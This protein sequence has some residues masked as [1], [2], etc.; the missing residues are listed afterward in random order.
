MRHTSDLDG[1]QRGRSNDRRQVGDIRQTANRKMRQGRAAVKPGQYTRRDTVEMQGLERRKGLRV[2]RVSAECQP[3]VPQRRRTAQQGHADLRY[4]AERPQVR[5]W[6]DVSALRR[7]ACGNRKVLERLKAFQPLHRVERA[8]GK[9][10]PSGAFE[11]LQTPQIDGTMDAH[12]DFGL[13]MP[14]EECAEHLQVGSGRIASNLRAAARFKRLQLLLAQGRPQIAH[15]ERTAACRCAG[16]CAQQP[17]YLRRSGIPRRAF[18]REGPG[19]AVKGQRCGHDLPARLLQCATAEISA[20]QRRLRAQC[21]QCFGFERAF[22][23][24]GE[25]VS[26]Q[27]RPIR[28]GDNDRCLHAAA[29]G[30]AKPVAALIT[31]FHVRRDGRVRVGSGKRSGQRFDAQNGIV[32]E[33]LIFLG[34]L[35]PEAIGD[36]LA[37][38]THYEPTPLADVDAILGSIDGPI[39]RFTF[40]D[41]GAGMG[42]MLMLAS[43]CPFRQ[44]VGIEVSSA[45]CAVARENVDRWLQ[46]RTDL[47]CRDIRLRTADAA[48]VRLPAGALFVY[49]YNPFGASTLKRLVDRLTQRNDELL[50][51]YHTPVHRV[52]MDEHP[53]LRRI[54]DLPF[55]AVYHALP[56]MPRSFCE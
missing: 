41:A 21:A 4:A 28:M 10:Q 30:D 56:S 31:P 42:R 16:E 54:V 37:D 9:D 24:N 18:L 13:G 48:D 49:L 51:A 52:V 47:R 3:H 15:D 40:V 6:I 7:R 34:E 39:E 36:A 33:A 29:Q 43:L 8:R 25:E 32:T 17:F 22:C 27:P 14:F 5:R 50:I 44:I 1:A 26:E 45:L 20:M 53:A 46:R 12:A 11:R 2:D 55:A 35:D 38:A 23:R 19:A